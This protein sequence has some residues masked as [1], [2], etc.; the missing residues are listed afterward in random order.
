MLKPDVLLYDRLPKLGDGTGPA[1]GTALSAAFA[2][3]MSASL[4]S[5]GAP[6]TGLLRSMRIEPGYIFEIPEGILRR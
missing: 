3:G 5:G 6:T 1:K 2:A 4:V